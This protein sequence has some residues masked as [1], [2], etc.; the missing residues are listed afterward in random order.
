MKLI[1][2]D[3]DRAKASVTITIDIENPVED[4]A[5]AEAPFVITY[6]TDR[7]GRGEA[8]ED[9]TVQQYRTRLR[10]WYS[11]TVSR[12]ARLMADTKVISAPNRD[13]VRTDVAPA[14]R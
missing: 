7:R 2:A 14:F 12:E 13:D 9:E 6:S 4:G 3:L 1:S 5:E 11:G 10:E 8:P